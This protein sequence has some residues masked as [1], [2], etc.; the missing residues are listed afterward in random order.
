M[1]WEYPYS[2]DFKRLHLQHSI[3]I[4]CNVTCIL[5]FLWGNTFSVD[6]TNKHSHRTERQNR[7]GESLHA[8]SHPDLSFT[9]IFPHLCRLLTPE[10]SSRDLNKRKDLLGVKCL[11]QQRACSGGRR[12]SKV[13]RLGLGKFLSFQNNSLLTAC[14]IAHGAVCCNIY[15]QH[16]DMS[17]NLMK[18]LAHPMCSCGM[19][20]VIVT[21]VRV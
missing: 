2:T 1:L 15:S 14:Y 6:S 11:P 17:S 5:P 7:K 13:G 4:I 16:Q 8:S 3:H 18:R 19:S 10:S 12:R 20:S 21:L 9:W